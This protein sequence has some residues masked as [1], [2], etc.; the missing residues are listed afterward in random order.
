MA[1]ESESIFFACLRSFFKTVFVFFGI[2]VGLLLMVAMISSLSSAKDKEVEQNY[3]LTIIPNADGTRKVFSAK[4]PTILQL[5]VTGVIGLSNLTADAIRMQLQESREGD[6]K[7]GLV[8]GILLNVNTP[9]GTVVDS[10]GIYRILKEYKEK[11]KVPVIAYVD[12]MCA[13]GGM[14]VASAADRISASKVSL[15]GS[16]GVLLPTFLNFSPLLEKIG[17]NTMTLTAGKDKDAM[18]PLRPWKPGEENNIRS[19]VDYYYQQF[20]DLVASNRPKLSKEKLIDEYGAKIFPAVEAQ[21]FGYIDDAEA[22][23]TETLLSIVKAAGL[24]G[25][26]YQVVQMENKNWLAELFKEESPLKTGIIKHQ[27]QVSGSA[28]PSELVNQF[29]YLYVPERS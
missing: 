26:A 22:N 12:G 17:V 1:I 23:Y 7:D 8:K 14:Y 21:A 10:D 24:E 27:I 15:V 4:T 2:A 9:G 16:V 29:L 18:N 13:S 6:L 20:V 25:Q 28:L 3:K 19:I 5:N 11:Y